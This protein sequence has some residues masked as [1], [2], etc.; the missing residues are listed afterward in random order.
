MTSRIVSSHNAAAVPSGK[1]TMSVRLRM[2]ATPRSSSASA[3]T[4]CAS[5]RMA[6]GSA[7]ARRSSTS[8]VASG[9]ISA[10]L[11]PGAGSVPPSVSTRSISVSSH[12]VRSVSAIHVRCEATARSSSTTAP[13]TRCSKAR[14]ASRAS[15]SICG[16]QSSAVRI[17]RSSSLYADCTKKQCLR[18]DSGGMFAESGKPHTARRS[19][20]WCTAWPCGRA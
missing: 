13:G 10:A 19:S 18:K 15:S 9:T 12:H 5:A 11:G 16:I 7:G 17:M 6:S 3:D 1:L 4:P 8:S 20:A 14:T 2:P